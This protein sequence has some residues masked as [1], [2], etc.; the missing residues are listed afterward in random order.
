M[1]RFSVDDVWWELA[2]FDERVD[3]E[4]EDVACGVYA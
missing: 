2:F 3:C 4:A 1:G